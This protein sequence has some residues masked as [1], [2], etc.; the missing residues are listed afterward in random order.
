MKLADNAYGRVGAAARL[1]MGGFAGALAT[2]VMDAVTGVFYT[3]HIKE[4][5]SAISSQSAGAAVATRMLTAL[6]LEPDEEDAGKAA[7]VLH[8]T[9]GIGA[10]MM[11]GAL[12]GKHARG[13]IAASAISTAG[14]LCFDEFGLSAIGAMPPSSRYPWQ[15]NF[16]S[17]VGHVA[18]GIVL[19]LAYSVAVRVVER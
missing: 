10:G 9:I 13:A 16:R 6:G 5:E 1:G 7:S 17:V 4:R 2:F 3:A 18:F 11:A 8:W 15:T 12:S 14:M 19:T